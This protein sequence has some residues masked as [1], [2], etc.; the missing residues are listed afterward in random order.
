M[1]TLKDFLRYGLTKLDEPIYDDGY[2]SLY[3][4]N[5]TSDF[6]GT[7]F[8]TKKDAIECWQSKRNDN[9]GELRL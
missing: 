8:S 7:Y 6:D 5:C 9:K 4:G 1:Q 2:K 3:V